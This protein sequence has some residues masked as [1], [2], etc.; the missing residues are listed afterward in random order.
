MFQKLQQYYRHEL[1]ILLFIVHGE[2]SEASVVVVPFV[3]AAAPHSNV[4]RPE[5][6]T[7]VI[8]RDVAREIIDEEV[9]HGLLH[10]I[11]GDITAREDSCFKA[12]GS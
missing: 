4:V 5:C 8:L 12:K 7:N 3:D 11:A 6:G 9:S 2:E 10:S 1:R